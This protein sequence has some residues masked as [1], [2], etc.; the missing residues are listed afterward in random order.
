M[1]ITKG[2]SVKITNEDESS[3][4]TYGDMEKK[5]YENFE[6]YSWWAYDKNGKQCEIIIKDFEKEKIKLFMVMYYNDSIGF[7]YEIEQEK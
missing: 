4:M 6:C 2:K 7:E 5:S 1:V 3:Y